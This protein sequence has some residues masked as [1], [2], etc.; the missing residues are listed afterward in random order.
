M[1]KDRKIL[2][3][4]IEKGMK[5]GHKIKFSGEADEMPG[6]VPGD[7]VIMVQEKEHEVFARKG[8]DLVKKVRCV[9]LR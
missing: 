4:N 2:E 6:T 7:V 8:A 9:E 5:N 1:V 3:V